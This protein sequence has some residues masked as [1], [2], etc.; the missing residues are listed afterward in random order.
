LIK[1]VQTRDVLTR[2]VLTRDV[3][4]R[5]VLT[6]DVLTGDVSTRNALVV[7]VVSNV[8]SRFDRMSSARGPHG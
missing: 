7:G 5:D 4:T 1:D 6:R 2:D 3:L 8:L